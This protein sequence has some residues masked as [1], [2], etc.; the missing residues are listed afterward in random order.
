[1]V[2]V[3]GQLAPFVSGF[4]YRH[5]IAACHDVTDIRRMAAGSS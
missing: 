2:A 4:L 3:G 5:T 1:M